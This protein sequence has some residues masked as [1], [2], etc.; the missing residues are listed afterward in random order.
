MLC[1]Q[2]L[3]VAE[4]G[5]HL[6]EWMMGNGTIRWRRDSREQAYP[7]SRMGSLP[8][9]TDDKPSVRGLPGLQPEAVGNGRSSAILLV[10]RALGTPNG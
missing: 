10:A 6:W 7:L 2:G 5:F 1:S 9:P 3:A 8:V 4:P